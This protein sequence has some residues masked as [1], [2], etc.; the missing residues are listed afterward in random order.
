[1]PKALNLHFF[2]KVN[3]FR[4]QLAILAIIVCGVSFNG[5]VL[6]ENIRF[7]KEKII[8][9]DISGYLNRFLTLRQFMPKRGVVGYL[10]D[11]SADEDISTPR[12]YLAQYSL[13]P[14]ILARSLD[15]S[16]VVGNFR[17]RPPDFEPYRKMG[18]IPL[19]DFG[20]G[21]VLFAREFK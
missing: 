20:N 8:I 13:A 11:D 12:K 6:I 21:V 10:S 2:N 3:A 7:P 19:R 9:M 1:M 18:L 5:Y 17:N 16:L 15:Y 4:P 14:V